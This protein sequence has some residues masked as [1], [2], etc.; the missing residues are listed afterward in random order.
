MSRHEVYQRYATKELVVK[1]KEDKEF[2]R[3]KRKEGKEV[4]CA[5]TF[6]I[7]EPRVEEIIAKYSYVFEKEVEVND[8]NAFIKKFLE[9]PKFRNDNALLV[10]GKECSE[11]FNFTNSEG[12]N[13]ECYNQII[14]LNHQKD[15]SKQDLM[16]LRTNGIDKY[17]V[18]NLELIEEF[19]DT[20][21]MKYFNKELKNKVNVLKACRW[22]MRGLK[23][24]LCVKKI[25]VDLEM[26]KEKL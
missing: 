3:E 20:S 8:I 9:D 19:I 4:F 23:K 1:I 10:E 22:F 26:T 6:V 13:I 15:V 5:L 16:V 11:V 21:V 12:T 25:K 7:K 17:S 14:K 2:Y 18:M 24:E